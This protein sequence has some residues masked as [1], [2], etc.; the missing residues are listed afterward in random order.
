MKNLLAFLVFMSL[1]AACEQ[2]IVPVRKTLFA[3]N[4]M[5]DHPNWRLLPDT[6]RKSVTVGYKGLEVPMDIEWQ[7][8]EDE[9]GCWK[10]ANI[11]FTQ[12]AGDTSIL[13][14]KFEF[15]RNPC[16]YK[17]GYQQIKKFESMDINFEYYAKT[18]FGVYQLKTNLG[19]IYGDGNAIFNRVYF[20]DQR[21]AE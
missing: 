20:L 9:N 13:I 6:I 4:F 11:R 1:F 19:V 15:K 8:A 12:T 2:P 7:R 10:I 17:K 21:G 3:K 18:R 14:H 5:I 16:I